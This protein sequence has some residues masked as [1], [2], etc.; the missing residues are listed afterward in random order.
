MLHTNPSSNLF[1]G[2]ATDSDLKE[3]MFSVIMI[4]SDITAA[5][6]RGKSCVRNTLLNI[7]PNGKNSRTR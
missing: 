3:A 7:L 2:Y 4:M 5:E 1:R 6:F